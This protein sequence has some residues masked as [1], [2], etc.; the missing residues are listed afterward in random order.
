VSG[1]LL[2]FVALFILFFCYFD[3]NVKFSFKVL[4]TERERERE[5][6]RESS[7]FNLWEFDNARFNF[8]VIFRIIIS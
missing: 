3:K 2:F 6:E 8:I 4:A 5:R 1:I 7:L